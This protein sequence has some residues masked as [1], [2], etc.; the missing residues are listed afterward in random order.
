MCRLIVV[1]RGR[2]PT[3]EVVAIDQLGIEV[4]SVM[5]SSRGSHDCELLPQLSSIPESF[6]ARHV[7]RPDFPF[8]EPARR[9][10]PALPYPVGPFA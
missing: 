3:D 4:C 8:G 9:F 10:F 7:D 1:G 5:T 2:V 6:S